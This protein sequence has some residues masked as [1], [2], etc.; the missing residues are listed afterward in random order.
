ML[1]PL[2]LPKSHHKCKDAVP[3]LLSS[4]SPSPSWTSRPDGAPSHTKAPRGSTRPVDE[5]LEALLR[6][7]VG[8]TG[9]YPDKA[10]RDIQCLCFGLE[11]EQLGMGAPVISH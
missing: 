4:L 9:I 5:D 7:S 8:Q 10:D 6:I 1:G 3:S 11:L 2:K